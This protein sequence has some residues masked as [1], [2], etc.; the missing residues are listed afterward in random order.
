MSCADLGLL[1]VSST[2]RIKLAA[3]QAAVKALILMIEGS[4]THAMKLSVMCSLLMS[5]PYQMLPESQSFD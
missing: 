3:S 2:D 5:T 4:Q 1:I